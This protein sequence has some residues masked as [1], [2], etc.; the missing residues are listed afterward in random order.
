VVA[1]NN[2][3]QIISSPGSREPGRENQPNNS[4][5]NPTSR[6]NEN[7]KSYQENGER[8]MNQEQNPTSSSSNSAPTL[9]QNGG[10]GM[11]NSESNSLNQTSR[12]NENQKIYQES[13]GQTNEEQKLNATGNSPPRIYHNA[14]SAQENSS[15]N[16]LGATS[17][18]NGASRTYQQTNQLQN[19]QEQDTN[20]NQMP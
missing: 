5:L 16:A 2:Q 9:D 6:P 15:S 8:Q 10:S 19:G 4:Q 18:E 7:Q 13:G 12:P 20:N 17:R 14:G 11:E 3:L 1:V